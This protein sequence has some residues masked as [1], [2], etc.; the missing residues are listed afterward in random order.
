LLYCRR[1][2]ARCRKTICPPATGLHCNLS[3]CD[4]VT[5][6]CPAHQAWAPATQIIIKIKLSQFLFNNLNACGRPGVLR[7]ALGLRRLTH[8]L[9]PQPHIDAALRSSRLTSSRRLL[10]PRAPNCARLFGVSSMQAAGC[11]SAAFSS[12][13]SLHAVLHLQSGVPAHYAHAPEHVYASLA[14]TRASPLARPSPLCHAQLSLTSDLTPCSPLTRTSLSYVR[15]GDSVGWVGGIANS[16]VRLPDRRVRSST[17]LTPVQTRRGGNPGFAAESLKPPFPRRCAAEPGRA[18]TGGLRPHKA[19]TP[20][21]NKAQCCIA[22]EKT[23]PLPEDHLS[24]GNG[25]TL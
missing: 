9:P 8:T 19:C 4:Q 7:V 14:R 13:S 5:R 10:A 23:C 24:S 18:H 21:G 3:P 12:T 16:A 2:H 6:G 25:L 15:C 11:G 22:G 17:G 1:K 20:V